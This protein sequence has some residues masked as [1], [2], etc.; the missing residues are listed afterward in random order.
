MVYTG[1]NNHVL[2]RYAG[3]NAPQNWINFLG[4]IRGDIQKKTIDKVE[5]TAFVAKQHRTGRWLLRRTDP[6]YCTKFEA[7]K[8][9]K[10]LIFLI[11][12]SKNGVG[13][14]NDLEDDFPEKQYPRQITECPLC[15]IEIEL[16][17]FDKNANIDLTAIQMGHKIP[18]SRVSN[19]HNANNVF[20]IHRKCNY[21]KGEQ[22]LQEA[23][24][25]LIEIIRNHTR[26]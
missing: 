4:K 16:S 25:S 3:D 18:L 5:L 20:W 14:G 10:K 9:A 1:W 23:L 21:I 19:S 12:L 8:I 2:K 13:V 17:D 7:F 6:E 22:T 11:L 26:I 24:D 15:K